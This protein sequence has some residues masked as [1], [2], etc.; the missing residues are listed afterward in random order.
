MP[1]HHDDEY[2]IRL[3]K[4]E[5]LRMLGVGMDP[6]ELRGLNIQAM[7]VDD[8]DKQNQVNSRRAELFKEGVGMNMLAL[9]RTTVLQNEMVLY[10]F[11]R[12]E[13]NLS[14]RPKPFNPSDW[15]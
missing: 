12:L 15:K 5:M 9:R 7:G 1:V 11:K 13:E 3:E 6:E 2:R 10:A 8:H 4:E 14:A